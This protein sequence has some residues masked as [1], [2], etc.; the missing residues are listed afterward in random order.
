[1]AT[2][3][4]SI[5]NSNDIGNQTC[6]LMACSIAPQPTMLPCASDCDSNKNEIICSVSS[7]LL[8]CVTPI[9]NL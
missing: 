7:Y 4:R 2:R 9:F 3:I 1:V 8:N 6:D 5:N